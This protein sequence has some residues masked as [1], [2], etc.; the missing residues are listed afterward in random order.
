MS[1]YTPSQAEGERDDDMPHES[2]ETRPD[3]GPPRTTPSQA[4][5][6]RDDEGEEER[7][8]PGGPDRYARARSEEEPGAHSGAESQAHSRVV[9]GTASAAE[10]YGAPGGTAD[11]EPLAGVE[12]TERPE[13]SGPVTRDHVRELLAARGDSATLVLLEG[14]AQ[15]IAAAERNTDLYAGALDIM[16]GE[17]LAR[18]IGTDSPTDGELDVLAGT[19]NTMVANLGA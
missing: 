11:D 4:E 6:E 5:G 10:G 8:L 17:E 14:R 15:V 3:Q 12:K 16:S 9:P 13:P 7:A 18:R 19:L 1:E 2:A